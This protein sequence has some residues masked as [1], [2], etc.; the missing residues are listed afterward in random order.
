MIGFQENGIVELKGSP[1]VNLLRNT[2]TDFNRT[3]NDSVTE[4]SATNDNTNYYL[5]DNSPSKYST[6]AG[7]ESEGMVPSDF[8]HVQYTPQPKRGSLTH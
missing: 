3:L 4:Y 1:S 5:D 6:G 2:G 7:T 8:K